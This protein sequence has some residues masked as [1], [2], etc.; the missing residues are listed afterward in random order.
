M[1]ESGGDPGAVAHD[2]PFRPRRGRVMPLVMGGVALVVCVGVAVGMG[3]SGGWT[4]GDQVTLVAFGAALAG[5]LLRYAGI[6]AVPDADGLTVRNLIVTRRVGWDE[7][8]EVSFAEGAPWVSL[9]LADDDEL[10]VMAVQ[11][12]DGAMAREE[13]LRLAR[14]VARH[15]AAH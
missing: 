8:V 12:A 1:S 11:R 6:R 3:V 7:V 14:L 13:A 2:A 4:P 15:R 5:F 10:A 9:E